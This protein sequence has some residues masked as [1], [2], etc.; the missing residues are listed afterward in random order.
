MQALWTSK[1]DFKTCRTITA[2]GSEGKK[3]NNKTTEKNFPG[4][5]ICHALSRG[6]FQG[7]RLQPGGKQKSH[8]SKNLQN[9]EGQCRK[10]TRYLE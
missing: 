7:A 3:V 5:P 8:S 9:Q 6:V 10:V 2:L 1:D 4:S